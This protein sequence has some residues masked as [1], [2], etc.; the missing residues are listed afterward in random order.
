MSGETLL[1]DDGKT[2]DDLFKE[3]FEEKCEEEKAKSV[4]VRR[5][6]RIYDSIIKDECEEL[7]DHLIVEN[8]MSPELQLMRWLKCMLAREFNE[9]SSL[10]C[11]DFILGGMFLCIIQNYQDKIYFTRDTLPFNFKNKLEVFNTTIPEAVEDPLLNLEVLCATMVLIK[12]DLLLESDFSMCLG[13]LWKYELRD[14]DD[15]SDVIAR[16]IQTKKNYVSRL[17]KS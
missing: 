3:R 7:Y 15:P 1:G 10:Q 4:I 8:Q 17:K 2:F 11:W 16:S 14:P 5:C 12:K 6:N 13:Y 9:Q